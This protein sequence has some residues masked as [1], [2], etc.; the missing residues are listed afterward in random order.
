MTR[1][2]SKVPSPSVERLKG[3]AQRLFANRGI[4]GVT[5]R[6]IAKA[7]GQKNPAAVGY[8]FGSKE[9]L[10]REL[11][12]DGAKIIDARRNAQLDAL[13]ADG[14][15]TR[16]SQIVDILVYPSVNLAA[17]GETDTYNRFLHML[18]MSHRA[19][20]DDA[21]EGRWNSGYQ[22]CLE[23]LRMLM[24]SQSRTIQ[25]QRFIFLE[26]YLGGVLNARETRLGDTS[27]AHA[28][29]SDASTLAHFAATVT[30]M[31]EME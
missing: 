20:F 19:L 29:W 4:D 9:A 7:A 3:E 17:D 25:N 16:I 15:P 28:T 5:V 12:V 6:D 21:L 26:S 27:R 2:S 10:I 1:L 18:T 23:H 8:H 31:L 13:E 11:I 24:P 14:G 22:R 30:W